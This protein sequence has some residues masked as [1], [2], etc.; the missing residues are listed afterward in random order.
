M[1][2]TRWSL[3]GDSRGKGP[4]D[5]SNGPVLTGTATGISSG[6]P[7][8]ELSSPSSLTRDASLRPDFNPDFTLV[9]PSGTRSW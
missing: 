2:G 7:S 9:S 6:K 4:G 8:N 1:K 3:E 5:H